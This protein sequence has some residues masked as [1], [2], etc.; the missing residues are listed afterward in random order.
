[1]RTRSTPT[2]SNE[3]AQLALH[4]HR[5]GDRTLRSG[6]CRVHPVAGHLDHRAVVGIDRVAQDL[7]VARQRRLHR[8]RELLP[9]ARRALEIGEEERD[10][11]GGQLR[12]SVP[13]R[14]C[15]A[16]PE[17]TV[18]QAKGTTVTSSAPMVTTTARRASTPNVALIWMECSPRP[19][20]KARRVR[21]FAWLTATTR[22]ESKQEQCSRARSWH[23]S[24]PP[25]RSQ[26]PS[27]RGN[28]ETP[29]EGGAT[30][31]WWW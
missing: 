8:V 27:V 21:H 20:L 17:R 19:G 11:A 4:R 1:M 25:P 18:N 3:S 30:S 9:Q 14:S 22:P 23:P 15:P 28:D 26:Q 2:P 31:A 6:E 10:C 7:V 13:L 24:P 12:H 29:P 5:R 16:S